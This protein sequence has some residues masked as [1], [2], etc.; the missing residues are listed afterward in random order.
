MGFPANRELLIGVRQGNLEKVKKAIKAGAQINSRPDRRSNFLHIAAS[1]GYL[2][3]VRYLLRSRALV[4][5]RERLEELTPL[6]CACRNS[7]PDVVCALLR[8]RANVGLTCKSNGTALHEAARAGDLECVI[9]L[10][11]ANSPV[12]PCDKRKR[13]PLHIAAELGHMEVVRTLMS[14]ES[15]VTISIMTFFPRDIAV[16]ITRFAVQRRADANAMDDMGCTAIDKAW[17]RGW[18]NIVDFLSEH[19]S[20][21]A[22]KRWR[23]WLE[24]PLR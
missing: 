4:D 17:Q 5:C 23:E 3:I 24:L 12:D 14:Y 10:M 13:T 8:A 15:W 22:R 20:K 7:E 6:H 2:P 16:V 1:F 19:L 21:S 18:E 11:M 9:R